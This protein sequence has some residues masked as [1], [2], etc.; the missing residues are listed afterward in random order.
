MPRNQSLGGHIGPSGLL[1]E[2]SGEIVQ[3]ISQPQLQVVS[4]ACEDLADSAADVSLCMITTAIVA[5]VAMSQLEMWLRLDGKM[6]RSR[7]A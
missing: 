7:Q 6:L 1:F 2:V 5:V 3:T 4:I